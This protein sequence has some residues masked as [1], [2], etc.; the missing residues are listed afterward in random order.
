MKVVHFHRKRRPNA[1]FSIEGFYANV[2]N[3]LR[4]KITIQYVELPFFSNG[5]FRRLINCI[6]AAFKQGF[7]FSFNEWMR[8]GKLHELINDTL[9]T[10]DNFNLISAEGRK[11]LLTKF[12]Q[13]KIHW[14]RV[15]AMYII[16][17]F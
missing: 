14:S 16:S 1:N 8:S 13:R 9:R 2:R 10:N 17:Q 15:W 4:D 7:T 11:K 12:E 6:Y 5:V 3:E